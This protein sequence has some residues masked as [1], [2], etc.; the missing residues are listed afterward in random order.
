MKLD[1]KNPSKRRELTENELT[2]LDI[3]C[4][5]IS[6]LWKFDENNIL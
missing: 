3:K 6:E 1:E 4:K 2:E 5:E